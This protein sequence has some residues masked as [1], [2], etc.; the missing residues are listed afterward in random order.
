[1]RTVY[2]VLIILSFSFLIRLVIGCCTCNLETQF[3]S[4]D[5]LNVIPINNANNIPDYNTDTLCRSAI[6]FEII[7]S[8]TA[9]AQ[10]I[11]NWFHSVGFSNT[12]AVQCDC[13]PNYRPDKTI[14]S[15]SVVSNNRLNRDI[16]PDTF[17]TDYF[18]GSFSALSNYLYVSLKEVIND[19]NTPDYNEYR[20]FMYLIAPVEMDVAS[21]TF[22]VYFT[23]NSNL[24]YSFSE[25]YVK[26]CKKIIL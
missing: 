12:C 15:I 22:T 5:L 26:D 3:I 14:D 8:E 18:V 20:F 4:V 2:K 13:S 19:F 17:I 7:L 23:D 10:H 6:G 1:M 25:I 24:T 9:V 16:P 11:I 21:F